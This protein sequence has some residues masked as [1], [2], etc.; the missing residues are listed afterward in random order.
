MNSWLAGASTAVDYARWSRGSWQDFQLKDWWNN[1]R[2]SSCL[3][4]SSICSAM[5][6]NNDSTDVEISEV[7]DDTR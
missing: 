4:L 2:R 3:H 1:F 6:F 5:L 7:Y